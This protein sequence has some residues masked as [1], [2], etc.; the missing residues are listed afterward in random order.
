MRNNIGVIVISV[1]KI[2]L[3]TLW[4][5]SLTFQPLNHVIL[6]YLKVIPTPTLNTLGSLFLSYVADIHTL[7]DRQQE[8]GTRILSTR[9]EL[10]QYRCPPQVWSARTGIEHLPGRRCHVER[11]A[12]MN[13]PG[14]VSD[15]VGLRRILIV[16][17]LTRLMTCDLKQPLQSARPSSAACH[18]TT[19]PASI[20]IPTHSTRSDVIWI[21]HRL[22]WPA[23][24]LITRWM[25]DR[26]RSN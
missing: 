7:S 18:G 14:D 3:L 11:A 4:P 23:P 21:H 9:Y 8:T 20:P 13:C 12:L 22:H 1:K 19:M 17:S 6:G 5:W 2:H 24:A 15:S 16:Q 10:N 25:A 26:T